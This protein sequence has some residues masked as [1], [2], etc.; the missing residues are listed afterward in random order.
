MTFEILIPPNIAIIADVETDN[1]VRT[2]HDIKYSIKKS[3]GVVGSTAFY[4]SKRGRIVLK[5]KEGGP[6]LSDMLEEAIEHEG[7]EDVEELPDNKFL[8]WTEPSK[9]MAITEAF[10]QKFGLE[11]EDSDIIWAANEDTKVDLDSS[12][13]AEGVSNLLAGLREFSEVKAIFANVRQGSV[14]DDEWEKVEE[15]L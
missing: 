6:T 1:K 8:A 2:L 7:V 4:F 15:S 13:S 12:E 3:G 5:N 9:V 10:A 14:S 11:V